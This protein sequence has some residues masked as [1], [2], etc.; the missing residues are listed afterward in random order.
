M[1]DLI[2]S[3][4]GSDLEFKPIKY[5]IDSLFRPTVTPVAGSVLYADLYFAVEH[6]GIYVGDNQISNIVVDSLLTCDSTVR[7]SDPANFTEKSKM[8]KKIYVSCRGK[9][10]VGDDNVG[11]VAYARVGEKSFYG[12]VIK[13]CHWFSANC[14]SQSNRSRSGFTPPS[15]S[16]DLEP[17]LVW[18]KKTAERKLG[19]NKW[20][21]WDWD[22]TAQNE[23]E[24]DWDE[25][26]KQLKQ[27]PLTPE[28]R[29]ELRQTLA[30]YQEYQ[31]QLADEN[32]PTDIQKKLTTFGD[33]VQA[34]ADKYDEYADFLKTVGGGFSYDELVKMERAGDFKRLIDE[35]KNNPHIQALI[36]KMGRNYIS[37]THK[38]QTK[39]PRASKSEVHGTHPSDDLMRLLPS[40]LVNLDDD[41]L[42]ML[43]YAK[44]LE[45]NLITYQLAGVTHE[46]TDEE[47]TKNQAI[48]GPIVALL[49][50]SGS[51]GGEPILKAKALLFAIGTILKA[52]NRHLHVVLF[53]DTGEISEFK[54]ER[55]DDLAGLVRFLNSG[56][57]GGTDFETPLQRAIEIIGTYD[58]YKKA[59]IL[60]LSDGDCQLNDNFAKR[61]VIQKQNH[62][63]MVY[64]VLCNGERVS[65]NFSD[66]VLVL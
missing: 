40:E 59:D 32:L 19:A 58:N 43:F 28:Y 18:L 2:K 12:L 24:P 21:L 7:L 33:T 52:E 16:L 1:F 15:L 27:R 23:P 17:N 62:N 42:Q 50:T 49:D 64:S 65:D 53:G 57:G 25:I 4:G 38:R 41:D 14:V 60:M 3:V 39:I 6:S 63:C 10:A 22:N 35:M 29:E 54:L 30:D 46:T 13:N 37:E 51:M 47:Y 5:F 9:Q 66:E 48:T 45:K 26:N 44:L 61:F 36:K 56:F 11:N 20:L 55:R 34:V 8:G 31:A